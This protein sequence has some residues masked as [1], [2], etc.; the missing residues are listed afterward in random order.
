MW[1]MMYS[2][3]FI[4]M[5]EGH[6]L[7]SESVLLSASDLLFSQEHSIPSFIWLCRIPSSSVQL[8][9]LEAMPSFTCDMRL[10]IFFPIP[11]CEVIH[12][13]YNVYLICCP[14]H[15]FHATSLVPCQNKCVNDFNEIRKMTPVK[16]FLTFQ[17][18][19]GLLLDSDTKGRNDFSLAPCDTISGIASSHPASLLP[20][21]C[22]SQKVRSITAGGLS[23]ERI[24]SNIQTSQHQMAP[25]ASVRRS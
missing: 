10:C 5:P 24:A 25:R 19:M 18:V 1:C 16:A 21:P 11:R 8:P 20:P 2:F 7:L 13:F 15:P 6:I 3:R 12:I 22:L 4:W 23:S 14:I 9:N 17:W